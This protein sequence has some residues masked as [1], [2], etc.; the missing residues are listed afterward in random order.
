MFATFKQMFNRKNK[1]LQ[2]KVLYTFADLFIFKLWTSIIV[3]GID[4][5]SLTG[6]LGFLELLNAMGG[7]SM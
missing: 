7:G 3:T 2:K 6:N 1:D 4:K 5:D